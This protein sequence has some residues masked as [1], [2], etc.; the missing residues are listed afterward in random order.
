MRLQMY[1]VD[2]FTD[3]VFHGNP[4]GVIPLRRWLDDGVMQSIAMENNLSETAFFVPDGAAF[5]PALVHPLGGSAAVR[6]RDA[7]PRRMSS[8]ESCSLPGNPSAS[9]PKSGD[10]IVARNRDLQ[11][12]DFPRYKP[13]RCDPPAGLEQALGARPAEVWNTREDQH[14]VRDLR[15]GRRDPFDGAR[16]G[17]AGG[18]ASVPGVGQRAG[19]WG[20][21]RFALFCPV[22]RHSGRSGDRIDALRADPVLGGAPRENRSCMRARFPN[23]AANYSAKICRTKAGCGFPAGRCFR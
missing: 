2:A 14:Y 10:L 7:R 22:D 9:T 19:G 3:T 21:F 17:Q 15:I 1:R 6:A 23:G 11:V 12:M 16:Y 18:A 8:S 20:G 4:A 5:S 13:Q